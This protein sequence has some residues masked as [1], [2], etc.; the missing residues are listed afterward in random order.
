MDTSYGSPAVP[1]MRPKRRRSSRTASRKSL[2]ALT[3]GLKSNA[4]GDELAADFLRDYKINGLKSLDDAET[5]WRLH[6]AP[7]FSGMRAAQLTSSHLAKYVDQ[8]QAENAADATID[9]E[10]RR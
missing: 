4:F 3:Q 2:P 5:R 6:L 8:R 7:F 1:Q 9:R 10:P